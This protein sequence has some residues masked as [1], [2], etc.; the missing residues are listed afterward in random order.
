MTLS[1]DWLRDRIAEHFTAQGIDT[2]V[3]YGTEQDSR[4]ADTRTRVVIGLQ[5]GPGSFRLGPAGPPGA[6]G[7]QQIE[8]GY[9]VR[10]I[11]TQRQG[12]WIAIRGVAPPTVVTD[13]VRVSQT[14]TVDLMHDVL[15]AIH[16]PAHG[17]ENFAVDATGEW[18]DAD[19]ADA[20]YGAMIILRGTMDIPV[21]DVRRPRFHL[22]KPSAPSLVDVNPGIDLEVC[23]ST[24]CEP[25]FSS[26]P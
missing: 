17:S 1:V 15:R 11:A 25:V 7:H 26:P 24:H 3:V 8:P 19:Q 12:I 2:P 22:A 18:V 4:N 21:F 9:S 10:S 16:R 5:T 14:I 13:R 23:D 6:P 20:A